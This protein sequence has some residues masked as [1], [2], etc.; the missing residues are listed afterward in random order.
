MFAVV[1]IFLQFSRVV[2]CCG[3]SLRCCHAALGNSDR[4]TSNSNI[5]GN[6]NRD[7]SNASGIAASVLLFHGVVLA[8][9]RVV[10]VAIPAVALFFVVVLLVVCS[11]TMQKHI[12]NMQ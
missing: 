1:A 10:V 8:I 9:V 3:V 4:K 7:S 11:W 6:S 2:V 5:N 12:Y